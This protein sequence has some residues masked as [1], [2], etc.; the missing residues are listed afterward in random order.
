YTQF[1]GLQ[2]A[3]FNGVEFVVD[4]AADATVYGAEWET[5]LVPMEG[6][7]L[8]ANG[9]YTK[10]QYDTFEGGPCQVDYQGFLPCD[11]SGETLPLAPEW[12][13][14]LSAT[15][16]R[17]L[18]NWGFNLHAGIDALYESDNFN[19]VD[20]DER[21]MRE[22]SWMLRAR[23]GVRAEDGRWA[24]MLFGDN[25]TDLRRTIIQNDTPAQQEGFFG[26]LEPGRSFE[27]QGRFV[28]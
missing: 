27:L 7:L 17:E 26:I 18:F 13:H 22:A 28:F 5:M 10:S 11:I 14:T 21:T 2:I 4:N 20:L 15:W 25:L 19:N 24:V 8:A 1:Q 12:V 9:S 6:L 16:D 3:A 23:I